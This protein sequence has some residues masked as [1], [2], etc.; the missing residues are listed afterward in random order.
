MFRNNTATAVEAVPPTSPVD[1]VVDPAE[2]IPISH[3]ALDLAEPPVGGWT[4]YLTGRGIPVLADDVGRPAV[5]RDDA[6]QLLDERREAE[7]RKQEVAKRQEW[8]AIERDQAFRAQLG[9]GIPADAVPAGM[10]AGMLMMASDPER[11]R[12]RRESVL[13]HALS[14]E[15]GLTYHPIRDEP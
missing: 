12:P 8:Q 2:L 9:G 13:D 1:D 6:R 10:T 14:H 4:A 5:G 3:L 11:Q 15:E 7:V